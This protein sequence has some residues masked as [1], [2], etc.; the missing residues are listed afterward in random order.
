[1]GVADGDAGTTDGVTL[2]E[3]VVIVIELS[4]LLKIS[5]AAAAW[6]VLE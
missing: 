5:G 1:M 6:L 3:A 2:T 4:I